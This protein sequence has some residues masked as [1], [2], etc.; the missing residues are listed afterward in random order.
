[1]K[2]HEYQAKHILRD[3]GVAVLPGIVVRSAEEAA[4]AFHE[5]GGSVAV[6][7]RRSTRVDAAKAPWRPSRPNEVCNWCGVPKKRHA[8]PAGCW[9]T[10]W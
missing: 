3:A 1:M 10:N 7:K 4:D 6:V 2:I 9:G 5:L 8:S